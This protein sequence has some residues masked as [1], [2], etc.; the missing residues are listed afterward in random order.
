MPGNWN[1]IIAKNTFHHQR[2]GCYGVTALPQRNPVLF[3]MRKHGRMKRFDFFAVERV[4][5]GPDEEAKRVT[6]HA[7]FESLTLVGDEKFPALQQRVLELV[8][9]LFKFGKPG[10]NRPDHRKVLP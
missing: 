7:G 3:Q 10:I 5:V 2:G 9:R 8:K 6:G 1:E 4:V